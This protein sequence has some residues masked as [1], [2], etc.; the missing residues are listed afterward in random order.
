MDRLGGVQ[1]DRLLTRG[2]HLCQL[3]FLLSNPGALL[4]SDRSLWPAAGVAHTLDE[5]LSVR[6]LHTADACEESRPE[7]HGG[8]QQ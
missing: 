3:Y 1:H 5:P 6:R 4:D 2:R 8:G 7:A